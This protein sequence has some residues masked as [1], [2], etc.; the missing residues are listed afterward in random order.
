MAMLYCKS[1]SGHIYANNVSQNV[2]I[3][4][5]YGGG[6]LNRAFHV[7]TFPLTYVLPNVYI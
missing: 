3:N 7:S 2:K 4:N 1:R 5:E 6:V